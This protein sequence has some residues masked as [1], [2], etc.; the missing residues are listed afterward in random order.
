VDNDCT[1]SRTTIAHTEEKVAIA[2]AFS[3]AA[4]DRCEFILASHMTTAVSVGAGLAAA[5]DKLSKYIWLM[6]FQVVRSE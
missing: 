3:T 2:E 6:L 1:E 5:A 4:D